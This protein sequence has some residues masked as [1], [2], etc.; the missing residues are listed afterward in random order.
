MRCKHEGL[1]AVFICVSLDQDRQGWQACARVALDSEQQ[2]QLGPLS[3]V[4]RPM[5]TC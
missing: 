4:S 1:F 2:T 5:Q 3:D